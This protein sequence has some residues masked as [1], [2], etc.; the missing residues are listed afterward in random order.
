MLL[1]SPYKLTH[2]LSRVLWLLVYDNDQHTL[3]RTF[4]RFTDLLVPSV[5]LPWIQQLIAGLERQEAIPC[6][7]LLHKLFLTFPQAIYYDIRSV[8]M[9][10]AILLHSCTNPADTQ[11]EEE[12]QDIVLT[13]SL[14]NASDI[15]PDLSTSFLGTPSR[16]SSRCR[17]CN[18]EPSVL[19]TDATNKSSTTAVENLSPQMSPPNTAGLLD[20]S[21]QTQTTVQ[22]TEVGTTPLDVTDSKPGSVGADRTL[23]AQSDSAVPQSLAATTTTSVPGLPDFKLEKELRA[24][25]NSNSTR[26]TASRRHHGSS[27]H[28]KKAPWLSLLQTEELCH[29]LLYSAYESTAATVCAAMDQMMDIFADVSNTLRIEDVC[30]SLRYL[31]TYLIDLPPVSAETPRVLPPLCAAFLFE[32]IF[33]GLLDLF[34]PLHCATDPPKIAEATAYL[35]RPLWF[36]FQ[37][38]FCQD[39]ESLST[40]F[41]LLEAAHFHQIDRTTPA[42]FATLLAGIVPCT[43]ETTWK[44]VLLR[45]H[46]TGSTW[47]NWTVETCVPVL[48]QWIKLLESKM[49]ALVV[50]RRQYI[51]TVV[52][53]ARLYQLPSIVRRLTTSGTFSATLSYIHGAHTA[54]I[55]PG[56]T[57]RI[58]DAF[59]AGVKGSRSCVLD[60]TT[61]GFEL[62]MIRI[63]FAY[64]SE[65][66]RTDTASRTNISDQSIPN[67]APVVLFET[68]AGLTMSYV[69]QRHSLF[70][71]RS[72]Q[73]M[74]S[75]LNFLNGFLVTGKDARHRDIRIPLCY[76]VPVQPYLHLIDSTHLITLESL[77]RSVTESSLRVD[78]LAPSLV[79]SSSLR[80]HAARLSRQRRRP[81]PNRLKQSSQS[82][83]T[84]ATDKGMLQKTASNVVI[85]TDGDELAL[86][87]PYDATIFRRATEGSESEKLVKDSGNADDVA[88]TERSASTRV[89]NPYSR[90][91]L[92]RAARHTYKD[93]C[94]WVSPGYLATYLHT[95]F[96]DPQRLALARKRLATDLGVWCLLSY[97]LFSAD[98]FTLD[99]LAVNF[100]KARFYMIQGLYPHLRADTLTISHQLRRVVIPLSSGTTTPPFRLTPNLVGM[101]GLTGRLGELPGSM[102]SVLMALALPHHEL[103]LQSLLNITIRDDL[104]TITT[105]RAL[106][107]FRQKRGNTDDDVYR[108]SYRDALTIELHASPFATTFPLLPDTFLLRQAMQHSWAHQRGTRCGP[109]P[110][111]SS[112]SF[113]DRV[114]HEN[115]VSRQFSSDS[116]R[117]QD[118]PPPLHT[119]STARKQRHD[120][121][122]LYTTHIRD[123]TKRNVQSIM[124]RFRSLY[125]VQPPPYPHPKVKKNNFLV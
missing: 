85:E 111:V 70:Q 121:Q 84:A 31:A 22:Q 89:D 6:Y 34:F 96:P 63:A 67:L 43:K 108:F 71:G 90:D 42:A 97:V 83:Q 24:R 81:F 47:S 86:K 38:D 98:P 21:C 14:T 12:D 15:Q 100:Q 53:Q 73:R 94:S 106:S 37:K 95:C 51:D 33:V 118:H 20:E 109:P 59:T 5:W 2:Y 16:G 30:V 45:L 103:A 107:S 57:Q 101:I 62:T 3:S 110:D 25:N 66:S 79:F 65:N 64:G 54:L 74:V 77:Y 93:M 82:Q 35:M 76:S 75:V 72:Q 120:L 27:P 68:R 39:T 52:Q 7:A 69:M 80:R 104:Y 122:G 61:E 48:R 113:T 92:L 13:Q 91:L 18:D 49:H 102:L 116:S 124:E 105:L 28:G 114:L 117:S 26:T 17:T 50:D 99:N 1:F 8:F 123:K 46:I 32:R 60:R 87:Q 36:F 78:Q 56:A 23:Q 55:V 9:E 125:T 58:T 119:P 19:Y 29:Q 4:G 11:D 115:L 10:K 40:F 112:F 88:P 44:D 41:S